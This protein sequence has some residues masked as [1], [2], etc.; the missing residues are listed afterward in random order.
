M[1]KCPGVL[2]IKECD[3]PTM[4]EYLKALIDEGQS[5]VKIGWDEKEEKLTFENVT[6]RA[7][8]HPYEIVPKER[9]GRK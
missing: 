2:P 9:L 7:L 8:L 5:V 6:N 1:C 3:P 4:E